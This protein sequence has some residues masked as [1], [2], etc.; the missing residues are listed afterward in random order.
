MDD[1]LKKMTCHRIIF[2]CINCNGTCFD[3]TK[4]VFALTHSTNKEL[5]EL[6]NLDFIQLF[7]FF[8]T[9]YLLKNIQST[10]IHG[11]FN[12][13]VFYRHDRERKE[14]KQKEIKDNQKTK[15]DF[16]QQNTCFFISISF[17]S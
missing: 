2:L 9:F 1:L 10:S 8:V 15:Q 7:L 13:L 14:E 6:K 17:N 11:S 16:L 12:P 3:V 5:N 4:S